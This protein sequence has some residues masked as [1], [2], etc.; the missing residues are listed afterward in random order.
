MPHRNK[1]VVLVVVHDAGAAEIIA[2]YVRSQLK[3]KAFMCFASGP[4]AKI[5]RRE[6]I[7]FSRIAEATVARIIRAHS[8]AAYMLTG[9]AWMTHIE[10]LA[11]TEAKKV[12]LKTVVYLDSWGDYRMRFGYP[13]SSWK[14]ILPGEFW[15]G[16]KDALL[17]ARKQFAHA[18]IQLV[19]NQYTRAVLAAYRKTK[20]NRN[21]V[22]FLSRRAPAA[23]RILKEL[24]KELSIRVAPPPIIIRL[25][26][27]ENKTRY[28]A[29]IK[30]YGGFLQIEKSHAG[31]ES[32][33]ARARTVIGLETAAM[34][35]SMQLGITTIRVMPPGTKALL[36][37]RSIIS[38][39]SVRRAL[40]LI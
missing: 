7:S 24:L 25:H 10:P 29:V 28:N 1:K 12:G 3:H 16:D 6:H 39:S 8:D 13:R 2:G 18:R 26:P 38:V 35:I 5:F 19:P 33:L 30:K 11:I 32:D 15:V 36:P 23:G 17:L 20:K 31:L 9:T 21:S 14:K 27:A 40:P 37:Q 22:L 34:A 4:A